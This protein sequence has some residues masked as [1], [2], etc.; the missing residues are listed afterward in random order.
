MPPSTRPGFSS[1]ITLEAAYPPLL[2]QTPYTATL[3]LEESSVF[4]LSKAKQKDWIN[5]TT[6]PCLQGLK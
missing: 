3:Y 5:L 4:N 2:P 1:G 6:F